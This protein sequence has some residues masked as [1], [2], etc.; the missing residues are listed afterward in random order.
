MTPSSLQIWSLL[1]L[2]PLCLTG[3]WYFSR[4][5]DAAQQFDSSSRVQVLMLLIALVVS[6]AIASIITLWPALICAVILIASRVHWILNNSRRG[7]AISNMVVAE[8]FLVTMVCAIFYSAYHR[9]GL[10]WPVS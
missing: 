7:I 2:I 1:V 4:E 6:H 5:S 8:F 10:V 9:H 3:F